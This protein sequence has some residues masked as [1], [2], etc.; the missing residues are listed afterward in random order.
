MYYKHGHCR[1]GNT[2]PE[3]HSWHNMKQRCQNPKCQY[4]KDYGGRG[5]E[6]C[7]RWQNFRNFFKDMGKRPGPEYSIDRINSNGNYEPGNCRWVTS[8]EQANNRRPRSFGFSKQRSFYCYGPNNEVMVRDN[9][10]A[11]AKEFKIKQ[12]GISACL[13]GIQKYHHKWQFQWV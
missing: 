2:T 11:A 9:Q 7:D 13:N 10:R 6:V 5:I 3:Y 1:G 8:K 12:W 4:Y